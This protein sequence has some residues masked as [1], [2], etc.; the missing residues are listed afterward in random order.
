MKDIN[1]WFASKCGVERTDFGWICDS[2]KKAGNG[3]FRIEECACREICR[4][5]FGISTISNHAQATKNRDD[6]WYWSETHKHTGKGKTIEEAEVA[7]L[8]YIYEQETA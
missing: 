2:K 1:E 4:E 6:Q 7:C 3:K 5:R 8:K